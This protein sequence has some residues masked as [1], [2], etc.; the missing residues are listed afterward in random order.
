MA[1]LA[2]QRGLNVIG[3][4]AERRN[5][6]VAARASPRNSG[7]T[8]GGCATITDGAAVAAPAWRIGDHMIDR[9]AERDRAIVAGRARRIRLN[10]IDEAQV[11]PRRRQVAALTEI[12]RLRMRRRLSLR[13]HSIVTGETLL[14]RTLEAP[15][16]VARGAVDA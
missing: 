9:L 6:V 1:A 11:A 12:C 14:R 7:M 13:A 8:K 4:L 3:R 15:I 10:M 16:D 2:G 5:T